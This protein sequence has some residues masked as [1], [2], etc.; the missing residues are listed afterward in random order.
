[1]NRKSYQNKEDFEQK[2]MMDFI[3]SLVLIL[4]II[5]LP[6]KFFIELYWLEEYAYKKS[7]YNDNTLSGCVYVTSMFHDKHGT[8]H[9]GFQMNKESF[10]TTKG[11]TSKRFPFNA[12][13]RIFYQDIKDK[14]YPCY[15]VKYIKVEFLFYKRIFL[16][17]Y[18]GAIH[19]HV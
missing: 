17:D 3:F 16:Y 15:P 4:V 7:K 9:Y 12:K 2:T 6:V 19:N 13:Q 8:E 5:Y 10:S 11:V 14:K 18:I 1:M